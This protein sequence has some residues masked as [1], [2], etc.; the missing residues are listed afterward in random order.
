[1]ESA[2]DS[3]VQSEPLDRE[4]E[5]LAALV[6]CNILDT[7]PDA[8]FNSLVDLAS[9]YFGAPVSLVTL[10]DRNRQWFKASVGLDVKEIPR[11]LSFCAHAILQ[12]DKVFVVEDATLDPRFQD[13]IMVTGPASIRFYAGAPILT[14]SGHAM[15]TICVV[16]RQARTIEAR[17]REFLAKLSVSASAFLELHRKTLALRDLAERDPLTGLPNCR[18][19]EA[20]LGRAIATAR[21]GRPCGILFIDVDHFKTINDTHGHEFGDQFLCALSNRLQASVRRFDKVA[22]LGGDEFVVLLTNELDE[23]AL[24]TVSRRILDACSAPFVI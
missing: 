16:D 5:R 20:D 7:P 21:E 8:R 22:R 4:E 10:V 24:A 1:M 14:E 11:E 18:A 3:Y 2:P 17:D 6:A 15:G 23:R 13:N 9:S 12:P 19:L